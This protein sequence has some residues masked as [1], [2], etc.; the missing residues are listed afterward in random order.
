MDRART[1]R[2]GKVLAQLIISST[3][4]KLR[5]T[6]RGRGGVARLAGTSPIAAVADK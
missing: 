2:D 5:R 6:L 4:K 3:L 1:S